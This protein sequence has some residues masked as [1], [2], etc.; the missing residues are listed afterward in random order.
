M[1]ITSRPVTTIAAVTA[2]VAVAALAG[3]SA[4]GAQSGGPTSVAPVAGK[5]QQRGV[6]FTFKVKAPAGSDVY[7][8]VASSKRVVADGTL[9]GNLWFRKMAYR[10]GLFTK[11]TDTYPALTSYFLNRRGTYYWQAYR[12]A[13]TVGSTDCSVEGPIRSFRIR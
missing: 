10:G 7:V 3:S 12:I 1:T 9:A 4:L 13:C 5:I 8:R 11:K 2:A 6:P